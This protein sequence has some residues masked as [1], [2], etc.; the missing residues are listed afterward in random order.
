MSRYK[1]STQNV[2]EFIDADSPEEAAS[3]SAYASQY[4]PARVELIE[5]V[6]AARE[7][8]S[9]LVRDDQNEGDAL[10]GRDDVA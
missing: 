1:V 10:A 3:R 6:E 2:Q 5:S 4:D 9:Q 7:A 8:E